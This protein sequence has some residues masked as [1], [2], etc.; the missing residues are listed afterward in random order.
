[1]IS[2]ILFVFLSIV[3]LLPASTLHALSVTIDN[4]EY[5]KKVLKYLASD[6]FITE[7]VGLK[8]VY[9]G[10]SV[11]QLIKELGKPAKKKKQGL[12]TGLVIYSYT[13]DNE[14]A[15][16]VGIK[17]RKVQAIALAGSISSQYT[18]IKGARFDMPVHEIINYYGGGTLKSNKL[19]YQSQGIRFDFKNGKLRVIRIFPRQK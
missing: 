1:M 5:R 16:Q 17:N 4:S 15:M 3:L 12:F 14:T 11:D 19:L 6:F 7:G 8:Q 18:T 13:L 10:Q 9:I 2:R